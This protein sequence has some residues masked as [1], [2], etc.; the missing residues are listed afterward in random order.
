LARSPVEGSCEL[1]EREA[2]HALRVLRLR[3]GDALIGLDGRG[4]TWPLR[5][6]AIEDGR[7]LLEC[8]A[9]PRSEPRPGDDGAPL[10]W[11]EIALAL[12]RGGR[13][14]EVVDALTQLGAAAIAPIVCERTHPEARAAS[15]SRIDR[16]RRAA[17][18][19]CKQSGRA[20][21][22]EIE[23]PRELA[24]W[25]DDRTSAHVIALSL[26]AE[27][28]LS[29][30]IE[31]CVAMGKSGWTASSPLCLAV[32]PEGG[33]SP[34]EQALFRARAVELAGLGPH[35]LRIET[36][37]TAALAIAAERVFRARRA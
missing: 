36:A 5:I 6:R 27:E 11:I 32:G 4:G 29:D 31:R 19:A 25:L 13:A 33:F 3:P 21:L 16:W 26:E 15:A 23:P 18:E 17:A 14:E 24:R 34:S 2:E 22:P 9:D 37:A 7:P 20:W 28:S 1:E 10:A 30:A 8:T 12:P 35:T